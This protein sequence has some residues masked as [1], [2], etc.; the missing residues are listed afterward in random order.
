MKKKINKNVIAA[1]IRMLSSEDHPKVLGT[2][3][4]SVDDNGDG[5]YEAN[6]A[7]G[8]E[9]AR[10]EEVDCV[11]RLVD[12]SGGEIRGGIVFLPKLNLWLEV[13][14]ESYTGDW[15]VARVLPHTT[16]QE[17]AARLIG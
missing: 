6:P 2:V 11:D 14:R 3:L 9:T 1:A 12:K 10:L 13:E 4:M 5:F 16:W 17:D 7:L 15:E 8:G